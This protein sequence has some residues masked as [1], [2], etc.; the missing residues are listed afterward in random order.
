M[1]VVS[2]FYYLFKLNMGFDEEYRGYMVDMCN[3]ME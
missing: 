2:M 1:T 3:H